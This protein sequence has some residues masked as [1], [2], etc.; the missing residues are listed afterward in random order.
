M[1]ASTYA[2]PHAFAQINTTV[3][4]FLSRYG[5]NHI[6]AVPGDHIGSLREVC[7]C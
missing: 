6:H 3:D 7:V 1:H 5:S 2:W 4:E